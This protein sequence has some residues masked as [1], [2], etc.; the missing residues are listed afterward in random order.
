VFAELPAGGKFADLHLEIVE[1]EPTSDRCVS[2]VYRVGSATLKL[3]CQ[4]RHLQ[5]R[6]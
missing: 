5:Y 6:G 1:F 2:A 3:L 4:L